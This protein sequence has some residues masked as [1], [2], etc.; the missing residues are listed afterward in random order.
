MRHAD[1]IQPH[2]TVTP[3][4]ALF[5]ATLGGARALSLGDE[6]G[7]FARGKSAD[8]NIIDI[9]G[10]DPR[11]GMKELDCSEVL[12]LLMYRGMGNAVKESFVAGK[13]LDVDV[14]KIKGER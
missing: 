5:L 3:A 9:C 10:I 12:S 1:Y 8:F 11:Y 14:L 4:K 2:A 7:N 13:R 6:T